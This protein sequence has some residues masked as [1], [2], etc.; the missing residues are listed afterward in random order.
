MKLVAGAAIEGVGKRGLENNPRYD[1]PITLAEAG[2][3]KTLP[4]KP[5]NSRPL[6][7][8]HARRSLPAVPVP[9]MH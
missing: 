7:L 3:D 5:G 2:I 8:R 6:P 9:A 1:A 4:M